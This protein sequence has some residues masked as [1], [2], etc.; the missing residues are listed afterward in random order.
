[1]LRCLMTLGLRQ[2]NDSHAHIP[3][4]HFFTVH[5]HLSFSPFGYGD[6]HI[7]A[8]LILSMIQTRQLHCDAKIQLHS[9]LNPVN[10]VRVFSYTRASLYR[11]RVLTRSAS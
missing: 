7:L 5:Y 6:M 2:Q 8:F 10:S 4:F 9:V 3:Q 11:G 1:M